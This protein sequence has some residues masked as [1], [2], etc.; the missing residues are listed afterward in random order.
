[1]IDSLEQEVVWDVYYDEDEDDSGVTLP[2][3]ELSSVTVSE[4]VSL[5]SLYSDLTKKM[6]PSVVQAPKLEH[7]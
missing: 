3:D 1:M 2:F 4:P 5:D 6:L 7:K